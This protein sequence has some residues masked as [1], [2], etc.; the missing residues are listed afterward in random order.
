[1]EKHTPHC[2][3]P[4]VKT[5]VREGRVLLTGVAREGALELGM[6]VDGVCAVLLALNS[7]DFHKAM[8]TYAD[9]RIWQDVYRPHT[10]VGEIYLK[11]TVADDVVVVSFKEL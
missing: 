4:R 11:L 9:H 6:D 10:V 3:L 1:L 8:T 5:L 7:K 2:P